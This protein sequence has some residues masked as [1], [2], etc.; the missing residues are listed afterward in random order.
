MRILPEY[1]FKR[2]FLVAV[3]ASTLVVWDCTSVFSRQSSEDRSAAK[4]FHFLLWQGPASF[5]KS[6]TSAIND[7][8]P[9]ENAW[10]DGRL[11]SYTGQ[12]IRILSPKLDLEKYL[13]IVLN[14]QPECIEGDPGLIERVVN[15]Q[16]REYIPVLE[17][18]SQA[19]QQSSA[20]QG[21][22]IFLEQSELWRGRL[23]V[24]H[25]E[26]DIGGRSQIEYWADKT[27]QT[28]QT[29]TLYSPQE[30][31]RHL[32]VGSIE[33]AAISRGVLESFL[34]KYKKTGLLDKIIRV[35]M[36]HKGRNSVIF[37]RKDIYN[38]P[39]MRT[40]ISETWL[41]DHFPDKLKLI[42]T[43]TN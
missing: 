23:G 35:Q 39:L 30:A 7:K 2:F 5:N 40:L 3:M 20:L 6:S 26:Y 16:I 15:R 33:A 13:R 12:E 18:N 21:E 38:N 1:L 10:H 22:I 4:T 19:N 27:G 41:R 31:L 43:I 11:L 14:S 32:F 8:L 37:L 28:P 34:H 24:V 25:P 29:I 9:L 17:V 36:P 42:P